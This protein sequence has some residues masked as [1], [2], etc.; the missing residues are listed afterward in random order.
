MNT[1]DPSN[2]AVRRTVVQP[3][4]KHRTLCLALS[5]AALVLLAACGSSSTKAKAG[6]TTSSAAQTAP[7][8]APTTAAA[9]P[10]SATS[11]AALGQILVDSK[12]FTV[13]V[14]DSDKNGT[15]ACVN[16]CAN[17]WPPVTLTAGATL[18]TTGA[19][20]ADLTTVARPDGA[21]QV[22]YKGRPVYRFGGDTKPGDT[23]GEGVLNLWHAVKLSQA[24]GG[25]TATTAAP[26]PAPAPVNPY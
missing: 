6:S 7:T 20:A 17:A 22:A 4:R 10:V 2:R 25:T 14:F 19:L 15:I 21:Q 3:N 24:G 11:N 8:T 18:P 26:A 23:K 16:Q 9:A 5:V 1:G 12:G 13:Y